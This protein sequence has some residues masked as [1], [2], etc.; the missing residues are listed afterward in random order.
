MTNMDDEYFSLPATNPRVETFVPAARPKPGLYW[1]MLTRAAGGPI[2]LQRLSRHSHPGPAITEIRLMPSEAAEELTHNIT[3]ITNRYKNA[4]LDVRDP[5]TTEQ[6]NYRDASTQTTVMDIDP[7]VLELHTN[8]KFEDT[9]FDIDR[10]TEWLPPRPR[11]PGLR[12]ASHVHYGPV[13]ISS[14]SGTR[15]SPVVFTPTPSTGS[16]ES[17]EEGRVEREAYRKMRKEE[18]EGQD[19]RGFWDRIF[20]SLWMAYGNRPYM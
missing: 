19:K 20:V 1:V 18:I 7:S 9:Y 17:L 4:A 8:S 13:S 3:D 11:N 2:H 6:T 16:V 10:S 14:S 15:R 5:A 12:M